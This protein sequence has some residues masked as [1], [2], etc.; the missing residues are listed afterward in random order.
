MAWQKQPEAIELGDRFR[1]HGK[2][3]TV[4]VVKKLLD[5]EDLP[6]HLHLTPD[7]EDDGRV[8]TFSLAA[9]RDKKLFQRVPPEVAAAA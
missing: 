9:L 6:P 1:M 4:W 8:L 3:E 5:L 7:D 2:I